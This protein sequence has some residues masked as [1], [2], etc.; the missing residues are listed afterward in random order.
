MVQPLNQ[1]CQTDPVKGHVAA[2]FHSNQARTHLKW[3]IQEASGGWQALDDMIPFPGT[4]PEPGSCILDQLQEG[5]RWLADTSVKG[6]A[7]I[8]LRGDEDENNFLTL[9]ALRGVVLFWQRK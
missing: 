8:K 3:I 7:V 5:R 1:G 9:N 6:V 4:S 2:G